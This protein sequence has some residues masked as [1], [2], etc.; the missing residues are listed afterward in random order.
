[1]PDT[2]TTSTTGLHPT[3]AAVGMGGALSIVVMSLLL[4]LNIHLTEE[5]AM[6]WTAV[7]SGVFGWAINKIELRKPGLVPVVREAEVLTTEIAPEITPERIKALEQ[8]VAELKAGQAAKAVQD[9]AKQALDVYAQV[10]ASAQA[11]VS[12]T[13]PAPTD[14]FAAA[15]ATLAPQGTQS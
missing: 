15:A 12:A 2:Q 1:M 9:T 5:E 7:V 13:T 10:Q 11:A 8:V 3:T 4:H 6:A 14:P